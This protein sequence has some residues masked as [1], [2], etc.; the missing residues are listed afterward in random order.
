MVQMVK[1]LTCKICNL[2]HTDFGDCFMSWPHKYK[3][4]WDII[5]P[6]SFRGLWLVMYC[7]HV[8]QTSVFALR[9]LGIAWYN[10]QAQTKT[11]LIAAVALVMH[12]RIPH[13]A[14]RII[15]GRLEG[16]TRTVSDP[17]CTPYSHI[18]VQVELWA[19]APRV[20]RDNLPSVLISADRLYFERG[21]RSS[22]R[23]L[24]LCTPLPKSNNKLKYR[25]L[26]RHLDYLC[27]LLC[28]LKN[29]S[30]HSSIKK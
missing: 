14:S 1:S 4:T 15:A 27:C 21:L 20:Q 10:C 11:R 7:H 25:A 18:V 24:L 17:R 22:R 2:P 9:R 16:K 12:S 26:D 3:Y 8:S 6:I 19:A 29:S 30:I 5:L 23:A 28:I 13:P